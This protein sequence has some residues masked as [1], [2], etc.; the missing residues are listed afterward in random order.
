MSGIIR[1]SDT[2]I[3]RLANCASEIRY[4]WWFATRV[5]CYRPAPWATGPLRFSVSQKTL[6][7]FP[8]CHLCLI[9]HA[10][11]NESRLLGSNLGSMAYT[12]AWLVDFDYSS[13]HLTHCRMDFMPSKLP[14]V[15][16][17]LFGADLRIQP[18]YSLYALFQLGCQC[19]TRT[20]DL[21]LMRMARWPLL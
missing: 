8:V 14:R 13:Y 9:N 5:C 21:Q 2:S 4:I 12:F 17:K 7:V 15:A 19:R 6:T 1:S 3:H 11:G 16:P 18:R 10:V 20:C